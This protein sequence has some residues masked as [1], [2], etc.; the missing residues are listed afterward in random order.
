MPER[1]L[2]D[3]SRRYLASPECKRTYNVMRGVVA[4]IRPVA[5]RAGPT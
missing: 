3:E 2:L 5:L 1:K 4:R